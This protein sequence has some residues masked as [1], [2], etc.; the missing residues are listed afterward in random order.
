MSLAV[1]ESGVSTF[2]MPKSVVVVGGEVVVGGVVVGGGVC[3]QV[4]DGDDVGD[5]PEGAFAEEAVGRAAAGGAN[6]LVV[7]DDDV[8]HVGMTTTAGVR[9]GVLDRGAG[10][11]GGDDGAT[12]DACSGVIN[13]TH[14][15]R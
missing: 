11:D 5:P 4:G 8:V 15:A 14:S 12:A 1:A 6:W 7:D 10:G 2:V 9:E 13:P 3:V